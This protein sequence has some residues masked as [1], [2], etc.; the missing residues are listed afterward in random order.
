MKHLKKKL[1]VIFI[2]LVAVL[3]LV[4]AGIGV[5]LYTRLP[6]IDGAFLSKY[7]KD[8]VSVVRDKWGVPH[9]EAQNG[10]DAYF[11]YGF[12]LAQDRLFQM[13]L[14]RRAS[15]GELSEIFGPSLL[16]TDKMFRT[17]LLRHTAE[18]QLKNEKNFDPE[19]LRLL[20]AFLAGVND[21]I[22]TQKLPVE[23]AL[24]GV[25][26]EKF[27]RTDCLSMIGY[28]AF[29][30]SYT[31]ETDALFS[32]IKTGFPDINIDA[33]FPEYSSENPTSIM[34][35]E[36]S[37]KPESLPADD[38]IEMIANPGNP[39][40]ET[41]LLGSPPPSEGKNNLP[42]PSEEKEKG[43]AEKLDGSAFP[44]NASLLRIAALLKKTTRFSPPLQ[45]SNS[46]VLA[47]SRSESG[48]AILA[49]DLH[50]EFSNPCLWYEAHIRYGD[51][52][53][54]GYHLP[55][56]PFPMIAHNRYKAWG[57]S[58]FPND[59]L[60][61]YYETFHPEDKTLVMYKG[62]WVK[63]NTL[64]EV[65]KVKGQPD[66][67]LEIR[68]TP[69]GPLITDFIDGYSKEKP[70]SLCWV[71]HHAENPVLDVAY[72]MGTAKTPEEFAKALSLLA[73]PGLNA[74]YSDHE[75]NIAWW[76]AG[77]IPVRPEH[78]NPKEIL[79]GSSGKDELL[80]YVPFE[81]NPHLINPENGV[82]VTANNK[83][84]NKPVGAVRNLP[85]YW[86]SCERASRITELLSEKEKW[87]LDDLKKV[88]LDIK[89][90]VGLEMTANIIRILE[91][92]ADTVKGFTDV[93]KA[94]YHKLKSWDYQ[95]SIT[96]GG[97][98]IFHFTIGHILKQSLEKTL[99]HEIFNLYCETTWDYRNFLKAF[100]REGRSPFKNSGSDPEMRNQAVIT[101]FKEAVK[102]IKE[103]LGENV[104]EWQWGKVH[105]VEYAHPL[106]EQKPMNLI[107]NIG[108]FPAPGASDVINNLGTSI[109]ED[110]YE[111]FIGPSPRRLIDYGDLSKSWAMLPTGNSGNFLSPHYDDQAEMYISG[112]YRNV[113]FTP[114][115]IT[116][117]KR[118][119]MIFMPEK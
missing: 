12:T 60:D 4:S 63:I 19:A 57:L 118:H 38:N 103:K 30:F 66:V 32:I 13:E 59:D 24:L 82:I 91:Q 90:Y 61:L 73:S 18:T 20:D 8:R 34:D 93:E 26:P 3:T 64:E 10:Q 76:A 9:I 35:A 106:G 1:F 98:V 79:D 96:S 74:S 70:V 43:N 44:L 15:K 102:V 40:Q 71:F 85:G 37:Y 25:K 117:S 119:E 112:E 21:F 69:H 6:D 2:S 11:A 17:F 77:K 78:V 113:N 89:S 81:E 101:A 114:E 51:Y 45:G 33:L 80:G 88:Q 52:E 72:R 107:F 48:K 115:Q 46:W 58:M 56:L 68:I 39:A 94:A 62:E 86:P 47:P 99:G 65:I 83:P 53:N 22:D 55:L 67:K 14:Q 95:N 111:V 110:N 5:Y 49:N 105:T 50:V 92:N 54:Y 41:G 23:F 7:L 27:T 100:L 31:F 108:P 109:S 75:G 29:N 104:E 84:T 42:S 16:D 87:N 116:K 97:A 28:M 36:E